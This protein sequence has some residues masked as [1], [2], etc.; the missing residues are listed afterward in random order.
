MTKV[1]VFGQDSE[2][3]KKKK[4]IEF[5]KAFFYKK[6][7]D[8]KAKP[9]EYEY[10]VLLEKNYYGINLSLIWAYDNNPNNGTLYLGHWNDGVV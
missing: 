2:E 10:V 6:F 3:E 1:S 4:P 8:A 5:V 7:V 9:S